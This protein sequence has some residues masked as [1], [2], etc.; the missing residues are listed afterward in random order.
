MAA[1]AHPLLQ[2]YA[3]KYGA[4]FMC[5]DRQKISTTS[6][7]WEKFQIY[8]LLN[9]YDRILFIDT[10]IIIRDD[11]PDLF[12]LVPYDCLGAFNE[13][14]WTERSKELMIDTCKAYNVKLKNWNG[15]YYNTGVMVLSR[16]HKQLFKKPDLEY[17]SFY[18]QT[19][20]NMKIAELEIKIQELDYKF[21]RMNCMDR[22][23]GEDR[24]ASYLIHYAGCPDRNL[25]VQIMKDDLNKWKQANG[26]YKF[27]VHIAVEINGGMGDQVAAE[28]AL[29]GLRKVYPEADIVIASHWPRLFEHLKDSM[30]V[31]KHGN[32]SFK[33]DTPYYIVRTLPDPDSLQWS[34]VSHLMCHTTD[35]AS[36]ALLRRQ[37][38][39]SDRQIKLKVNGE[40][41]DVK[42]ITGE[43]DL[44]KL[45]L[46]HPGKHWD[47]KTFPVEY[48]QT[49]IDGLAKNHAVAIIGK[50]DQNRGTVPVTCPENAIDLRDRLE[51]GG[52]IALISQAGVLVSNDSAPVHIAGAFDNWIVLLPSCKHPD[53]VL[54]YR[55]NGL[56]YY[57]ALALYKKLPEYDSRPTCIGGSSAEKIPGEWSEYLMDPEEV[58]NRVEGL[59]TRVSLP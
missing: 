58:I 36:M 39:L 3:L 44:S 42:A 29:R 24:H 28:P 54:P 46:V 14:P 5:I 21:N 59:C 43:M 22:V 11:T 1:I 50:E 52:L 53:H 26:N 41:K 16:I 10:D 13:A 7:H 19:Y 37:L 57:K 30:E 15:K 31:Y 18:E 48:W 23:T 25:I 49:I 33:Q 8:D 40:I 4:D 56:Q 9:T 27:Q 32:F 55:K 38:P 17:F 34:V 6:I 51:L 47:S 20:L 35:Y 45:I 2:V 12:E